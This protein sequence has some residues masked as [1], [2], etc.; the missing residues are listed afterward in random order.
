MLLSSQCF[1]TLGSSPP[2]NTPAIQEHSQLFQ[3][4]I[5][6]FKD[7]ENQS[8]A[9]SLTV[10]ITRKHSRLELESLFLH[11]VCVK[12]IPVF[13]FHSNLGCFYLDMC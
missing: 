3:S 8:L 5:V 11:L 1:S 10:S 13:I 2:P 4:K 6:T 7:G 9:V 12:N